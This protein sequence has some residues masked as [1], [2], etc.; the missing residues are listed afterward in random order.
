MLRKI[1]LTLLLLLSLGIVLPFANSA[2][3]GIRQ[4]AAVRHHSKYHHS[5]TWWRRY[6]ARVRRRRAAALA[7]RA[8]LLTAGIPQDIPITDPS[9]RAAL[10]PIGGSA[11]TVDNQLKLRST[12]SN[13][14]LPGQMALTVVA[15]SRPNPAFLT[16]REEKRM[17]AGVDVSDLRRIVIDKMIA[18]G[19]WVTNDLVKDVN[20]SRVFVVTARTPADGRTS[21]KAWSFYFTEIGG[22]VYGLTTSAPVDSAERMATEAERFI[23][24]FRSSSSSNAQPG[25]Q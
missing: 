19:G 17:L 10:M 23:G 1:T 20:G 13:V 11:H 8:A 25:N 5:R 4:S 24:S 2:A 18:E 12:D 6:R 21:E 14:S 3:H 22:R 16:S 7:H 15:L 9:L